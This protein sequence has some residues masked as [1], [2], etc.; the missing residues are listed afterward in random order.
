M[1]LLIINEANLNGLCLW[2]FMSLN[3]W[4]DT[5]IILYQLST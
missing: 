5:I 3:D 4:D 1:S 2:I